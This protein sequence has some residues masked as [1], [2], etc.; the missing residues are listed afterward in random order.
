MKPSDK[1]TISLCR[2]HHAEQHRIGEVS[3]ERRYRIDLRV[4]AEQFL[5]R[6]PY[7]KHLRGNVPTTAIASTVATRASAADT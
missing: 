4:L 2:D 3:F 5:R 1:W 6:S 7:A